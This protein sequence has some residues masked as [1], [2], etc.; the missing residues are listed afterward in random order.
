MEGMHSNGV[1]SILEDQRGNLWMGSN[2]GIHRVSRQQLNDFAAGKIA[3]ID[4]VGYGKADGMLTSE[5]V[6]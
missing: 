5:S 6:A 4:A 3:R 1:F 2:Q